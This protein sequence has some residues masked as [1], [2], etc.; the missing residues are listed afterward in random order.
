MTSGSS[1][2][3]LP[4]VVA[5]LA[6]S[7]LFGVVF[8]LAGAIDASASTIVAFRV[9]VTAACYVLVLTHPAARASISSW[10]NEATA[11]AARPLYVLILTALIAGQ[12]WLFAWSPTAGHALDAS[13]GY[14]LLPIALVLVG[15]FIFRFPVSSW[16]WTAVG[17]ATVA[18]ALK[19]V[20][21]AQI[22][23]VTLAIC[24]G[25][26]LYFG[27]RRHA[28]LDGPMAY[29]VEVILL[30]PVAAW[31]LLRFQES[32]D[33][34]TLALVVVAGFS[35]AVAMALYLAASTLLSMPMFGLLSYGEPIL[36]FVVALLLGE[37]LL[38][39]DVAVYGLLAVALTI[40]GLDGFRRPRRV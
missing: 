16:Q 33:T 15:R 31:L 28:R 18:V 13:L 26:A 12:L 32:L 40:L 1:P 37:Q 39:G 34:P 23:W 24:V 10:K 17:I 4:G 7:A 9:L 5:S 27:I 36:M 21:T 20:L 14:L 38:P 3:S 22:S 11:T 6:A 25:Y 35:G 30:S 8:Y 2:T 29:G 19:A